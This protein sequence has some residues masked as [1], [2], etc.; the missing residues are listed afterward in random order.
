LP[1]KSLILAILIAVLFCVGL[2][3]LF[4]L[5]YDSGEVYAEYSS[6][7]SD[8][9]GARALYESL[10]RMP[11]V[12]VSRNLLP[13]AK[14][15]TFQGTVFYLGLHSKASL[16]EASR[17]A[18]GGARVIV[19]FLPNSKA[20]DK[21]QRLFEEKE[22]GKG[23]LVILHDSYWVSNEALLNER[24]PD[25]LSELIGPTR[26][27][28]FDESHLGIVEQGS[29]MGLARKYGLGGLVLAVLAL[30]ALFIWRNS[31][32]LLPQLAETGVRGSVVQ[33]RD[34]HTGFVNLLRR[35]VPREKLLQT[36]HDQW[37]ATLAMGRQYSDSKLQLAAQA[38][39]ERDAVAAYKKIAGIL[40]QRET[41]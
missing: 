4:L 17:I 13:A 24:D 15:E 40:R 21:P 23:K 2:T 38:A 20:S 36:A 16:T 9:R 14:L 6:L 19:G 30:F 31:S 29:L 35:S 1:R 3:E 12:E 10:E 37:R 32:S 41:S 34:S 33:G 25:L 27:I 28:V 11:G 39:L 26:Q 8:P 18:S 7:R 22:K 5:R